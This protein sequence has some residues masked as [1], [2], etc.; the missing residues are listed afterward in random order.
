MK[1]VTKVIFA[2]MTIV[3]IGVFIVGEYSVITAENTKEVFQEQLEAELNEQA[4]LQEE[5]QNTKKEDIDQEQEDKEEIDESKEIDD[6]VDV[7][8]NIDVPK[9]EAT[10]TL[11]AT[12]NSSAAKAYLENATFIGDS[13]MLGARAEIKSELPNCEVDAEVSRQLVSALDVIDN[14]VSQGRIGNTVIFGLGANGLFTVE[15]GQAVIDKLGQDKTIFWVNA[16]GKHLQEQNS[17]N[18]VINQ[19]AANNKNVYVLDWA[20]EGAKNPTWFYNDGMHLNGDGRKGY[21]DFI[22]REVNAIIQ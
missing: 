14:L 11:E 21:K 13:V 8:D 1:I 9:I 18:D 17:I 2:V 22:I 12:E 6:D 16:Y 7:E 10:A 5:E 19:V 15:Q 4:R 20:T 3:C